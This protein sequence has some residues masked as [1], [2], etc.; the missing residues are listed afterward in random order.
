VVIQEVVGPTRKSS[1][2][3][4]EL[5][6]TVALRC[7]G[8]TL[9]LGQTIGPMA[10]ALGIQKL[11]VVKADIDLSQ[12]LRA[13]PETC[14]LSD[15]ESIIDGLT[16]P[17]EGFNT[18][19]LADILENVSE[20]VGSHILSRVWTTLKPGGRLI[21]IVPNEDCGRVSNQVRKFSRRR[22]KKLL[23]VLGKPKLVTEQ[24]FKWLMMCVTKDRDT[25]PPLRHS[26]KVRYQV[27]ANL[28]RGKVIEMGCGEGHLT[29]MIWDRQLD[30]VGVDISKMKI[31]RARD[32][33]PAIS[34]MQS[35]VL[36]LTLPEQ[37]FDSVVLAEI[38]E[39]I[40]DDVGT[41][42]LSKAG[43]LLRPGGR[44]IVSV[45]NEDCIPHPNHIRQFNRRTMK[46]MMQPFGRPRLVTDQPFKWLLMYV[47]CPLE[48]NRPVD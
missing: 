11:D 32:Q 2:P 23:S 44:L 9:V 25:P 40:S 14:G 20:N 42:M 31:A 15:I 6:R 38:L 18:V 39:H 16:L 45:P 30:V 21:V 35:D 29:K 22:F 48:V 37:G 19:V 3:L 1:R 43:Q 27:T 4:K 8:E 46:E 13:S 34:F 41:Q 5:F 26:L 17:E 28:C 47:D 24:P 12:L 7:H 10:D 36:D 33:Y